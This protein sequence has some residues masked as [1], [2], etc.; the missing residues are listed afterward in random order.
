MRTDDFD[1]SVV[2]NTKKMTVDD[3]NN[4]AAFSLYFDELSPLSSALY[5]PK[6]PLRVTG[7]LGGLSP[8][9]LHVYGL[10]EARGLIQKGLKVVE[11]GKND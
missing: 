8:I 10:L 9:G 3:F 11:G 1:I 4:L 6:K 2:I 7:N 5:I